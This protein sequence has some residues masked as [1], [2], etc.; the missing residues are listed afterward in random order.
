MHEVGEFYRGRDILIT[1]GLGFIGSSLAHALVGFGARVTLIDSLIPDYGGNLANIAGLE[2]RVTV[3][4]AD[5]RDAYSMNWL[6]KGRDVIFNLAGTL[7]HTD[8]MKDPFTDLQINCV[9]QLSILEA[10]RKNNPNVKILFAGTRGQYGRA[11]YLPVDEKHPMNPADVNGINNV[12]GEAYHILYNNVY[13]LRACS[14]RLTNTFGPRHQMRHHRQGIINWFV[15]LIL[16]G[17]EVSVFGD[18]TQVRDANYIDDVVDAFLLAG[19]SDEVDGQVYNLGGTPASLVEI[20]RTLVDLRGGSWKLVPF[21]AE[22]KVIEI[23]DYVA[24]TDKIRDAL[25]WTARWN[26]RDGLERTIEYYDT[27][28]EA[29]F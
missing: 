23:G 25:G 16:E 24:K 13:G 4:I 10:C 8:S 3:N 21:P 7:S 15:R 22:A 20:A 12:A 26:L 2:G 1:G 14:L 27:R 6:V 18:G 28:R 11:E 9:S 17:R 5:V 19:A 29:Y